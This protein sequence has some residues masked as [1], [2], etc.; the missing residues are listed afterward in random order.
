VQ[1]SDE[2]V[3][4]HIATIVVG[5]QK[6]TVSLSVRYD[7]IEYLGRLWY[8]EDDWEDEGLPDRGNIPGRTQQ[9]VVDYARRLSSDELSSRFK[10]AAANRRRFV[11]LRTVTEEFLRKVRYL[12]QVAISMRAGLIDVGG[13]AQEIDATEAQLHELIR[14]LR[15]VAGVEDQSA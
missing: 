3:Q 6:Y 7:G 1:T 15:T 5:G 10:R 14:R 4:P 9:E 8:H 11:A 13:A 12:N 2:L